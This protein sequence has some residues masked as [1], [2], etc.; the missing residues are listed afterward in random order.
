MAGVVEEAEGADRHLR[1]RATVKVRSPKD[2]H[3]HII[4]EAEE[5]TI[6]LLRTRGLLPSSPPSPHHHPTSNPTP[7]TSP[8]VALQLHN[9]HVDRR[10]RGRLQRPKAQSRP[11]PI[12]PPALTKTST[13]ATTSVPSAQTRCAA[14]QR[15]SGPAERAG[16]CFISAASRNGRPMRVPKQPNSRPLTAN[17]HLQGNGAAQAVI[18]LRTSCPKCLRVGVRRRWIPNLLRACHLFP[19]DRPVHDRVFRPRNA[20]IHVL[21]PVMRVPALLV[22]SWAR[23]N[24]VSVARTPLRA[25]V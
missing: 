1:P 5:V 19:A 20:H 16:L 25:A 8:R 4:D 14:Q 21:Q 22:H 18:I 7:L 3:G 11:L 24:S 13:T 15:A 2:L 23:S 6:R 10:V 12:S 17:R 9:V